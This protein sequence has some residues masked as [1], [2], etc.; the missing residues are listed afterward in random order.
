MVHA[1]NE[2]SNEGSDWGR[3]QIRARALK[4]VHG[5]NQGNSSSGDVIRISAFVPVAGGG[6]KLE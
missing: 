6:P 4:P 3:P 5:V 1:E 2:L